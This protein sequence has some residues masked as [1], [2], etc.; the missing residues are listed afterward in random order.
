MS[1]PTGSPL[2]LP[3]QRTASTRPAPRA[4]PSPH[5]ALPTP[6]LPAPSLPTA[7]RRPRQLAVAIV[8]VLEMLEILESSPPASS[9]LKVQR[10]ER[11]L[12]DALDTLPAVHGC[13]AEQH[14]HLGDTLPGRSPE[15][16]HPDTRAAAAVRVACAHLTRGDLGGACVALRDAHEHLEGT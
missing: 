16:P 13:I 7:R 2:V 3:A 5:P 1:G 11:I 10:L 12:R 6:S 4:F 8:A 15:R 9:P 14:Q